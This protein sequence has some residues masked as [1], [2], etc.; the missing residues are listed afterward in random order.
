VPALTFGQLQSIL[1]NAGMSGRRH[2]RV[3]MGKMRD[4]RAGLKV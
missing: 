1:Q 4:T 3:A 2:A